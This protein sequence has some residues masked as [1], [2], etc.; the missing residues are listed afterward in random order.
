M[1]ATIPRQPQPTNATACHTKRMPP[2]DIHM[3]ASPYPAALSC[4]RVDQPLAVVGAAASNNYA[5]WLASGYRKYVVKVSRCALVLLTRGKPR[6]SRDK[7]S[8]IM[9]WNRG[10]L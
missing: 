6:C 3:I 4:E 5:S 9:F 2:R 7:R 1:R 8:I 10:S